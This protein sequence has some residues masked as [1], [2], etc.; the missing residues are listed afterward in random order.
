MNG[1]LY[2]LIKIIDLSNKAI[3]DEHLDNYEKEKY[4]NS[5]IFETVEDSSLMNKIFK[6]N[7]MK[8]VAKS[9]KEWCKYIRSKKCKQVYVQLGV[10]TDDRN[11]SAFAN[12]VSGQVMICI[13]NGYYEVWRNVFEYNEKSWDVR[14][15]LLQKINGE[16]T[17][18]NVDYC[19]AIENLIE[20]YQRIANF[21]LEIK[22]E[23]WA[24]FFYSGKENLE[25]IKSKGEF[26]IEQL[27]TGI[28]W[29]FGG[30]GSWNDSPP[31]SAHVLG[32]EDEFKLVSDN[33]YKGILV[34]I[35]AILNS[36]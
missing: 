5:I 23:H 8:V 29:P 1:Q 16:F 35:E 13:Y 24:K 12:G 33:L 32:K 4:I 22:E 14:Y 30:M 31:Y 17:L 3:R 20:S 2:N 19:R 21:A 28:Q 27:L 9:L 25:R 10:S 36:A 18:V 15:Q 6:Q 11:L 34:A 7:K 26:N